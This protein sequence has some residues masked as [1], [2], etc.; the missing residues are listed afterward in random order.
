M[1]ICV[2]QQKKKELSVKR[3]PR[4]AKLSTSQM[5]CAKVTLH[6]ADSLHS[7]RVVLMTPCLDGQ[8]HSN[9][10]QH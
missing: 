6:I 1:D 7:N 5:F 8:P 4:Q 2:D 10:N 9:I 3:I